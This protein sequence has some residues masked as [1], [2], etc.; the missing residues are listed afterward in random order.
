MTPD[1]GV[2]EF[3]IPTFNSG[4]N[5]I[6]LGPDGNLWFTE[7]LGNKIGRLAPPSLFLLPSSAHAPG[8]GGA[9]FTTDLTIANTGAGDV[10][11]TLKFLGNN[12]DGRPGA[13]RTFTL[14]AG[15]SASYRDFLGTVFS[16]TNAFGAVRI[17]ASAPTLAILSQT[18]TPFASGT[19][20]Q[21]IPVA[22][23]SEFIT[24]GTSRSIVGVRENASFRTNLVL[25]NATEVPLDVDVAVVD[26]SGAPLASQR[27]SLPP[28]GMTQATRV[29][30]A[31]G[32]GGDVN[33]A[34]LVLSTPTP[35]GAFVAYASLI[36]NGT[37]DPRTLLPK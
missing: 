34:R 17:S 23:G 15:R 29:V 22:P 30:R 37:N 25:A 16:L 28:L 26:E 6:A 33:G 20:G 2:T 4:P 19:V 14:A 11:Y 32:L 27:F 36:D 5:R 21:V 8:S 12:T 7:A 1:G 35:G 10:T 24:A 3:S 13:E 9:F 18:S 31:I